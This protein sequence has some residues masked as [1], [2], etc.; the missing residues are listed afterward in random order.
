MQC[1]EPRVSNANGA[2]LLTPPTMLQTRWVNRDFKR[3]K[4]AC[5]LSGTSDLL[6]ASVLLPCLLESS[7]RLPSP[8]SCALNCCS[9]QDITTCVVVWSMLEFSS[10]KM[11]WRVWRGFQMGQKKLYEDI[12]FKGQLAERDLG[13]AHQ[14]VT[15]CSP[16]FCFY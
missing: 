8:L 10:L 2:V 16:F 9:P 14:I 1:V 12:T 6:V 5:H 11:P 4:T 3:L 7:Y 15:A 13:W